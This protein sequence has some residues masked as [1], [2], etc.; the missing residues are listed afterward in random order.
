MIKKN[1]AAN[2]D[3]DF[4]IGDI[5]WQVIDKNIKRVKIE[6]GVIPDRSFFEW[7][8]HMDD[9]ITLSI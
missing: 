5:S 7:L 3:A 4:S 6:R 9:K 8:N 1:P 2:A